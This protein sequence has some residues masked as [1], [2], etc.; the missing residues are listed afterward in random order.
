MPS[1]STWPDNLGSDSENTALSAWV[2]TTMVTST[3]GA[4]TS[5]GGTPG[6]KCTLCRTIEA[7]SK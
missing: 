6:F 4:A 5:T 3:G 1:S 7:P 2:E